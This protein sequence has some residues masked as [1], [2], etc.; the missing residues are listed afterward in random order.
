MDKRKAVLRAISLLGMYTGQDVT[1]DTLLYYATPF[2]ATE[3]KLGN[4]RGFS[5]G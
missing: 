2:P 1:S 5:P 3:N 4:E